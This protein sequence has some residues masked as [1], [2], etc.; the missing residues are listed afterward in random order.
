MPTQTEMDRSYHA[1]Q[2]AKSE[3]I[4]G[5][6]VSIASLLF[7]VI[8]LLGLACGIVGVALCAVG[9]RKDKEAM[10]PGT[11]RGLAI[12]GLPVGIL[13]IV[14]GAITTGFALYAYFGGTQLWIYTR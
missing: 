6:V 4:A 2:V 11:Y 1:L 7:G 13:G 14:W 10:A 9:L 8:P 12:A 5:F 3:S